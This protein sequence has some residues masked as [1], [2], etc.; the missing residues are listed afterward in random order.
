MKY[1]K[2]ILSLVAVS[3]LALGTLI[4]TT[5]CKS[6]TGSVTTTNGIVTIGGWTVNT[7]EVYTGIE[8]A[9]ALATEV[10]VASTGTNSAQTVADFK[11]AEVGLNTVL[12][13]GNYSPTNI[14]ATLNQVGAGNSANYVNAGL[15]LYD[16]FFQNVVAQNLDQTSPY[17][18]PA[19]SG[20]RDGIQA[21]L[22]QYAAMKAHA[23]VH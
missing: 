13:S 4:P 20:I 11:L 23:P 22:G 18:V 3:L 16:A 2:T 10:A 9:T 5:G 19:L 14:T 15:Q 21:G 12:A 7:N 6:L 1:T 8:V 17:L